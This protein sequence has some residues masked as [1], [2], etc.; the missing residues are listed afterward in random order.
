MKILVYKR[1]HTGD[2]NMQGIF[3]CNDCMGRV[4]DWDYDAVIG[5]GVEYPDSGHDISCKVTWIGIGPHRYSPPI[6]HRGSLVSFDKFTLLD[7]SGPL[8]PPSLHPNRLPRAVILYEG[9]TGYESAYN[10]ALQILG[11]AEKGVLSTIVSSIPRT[12][13]GSDQVISCTRRKK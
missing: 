4:R 3:G 13:N 1:T 2:P 7:Q 6:G 5:V 11:Q 10:E 8:A 9:K 12:V